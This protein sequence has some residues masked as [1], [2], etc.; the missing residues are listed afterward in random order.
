MKKLSVLFLS[1]V[2]LS[3]SVVSCSSDDDKDEAASIEGKWELFQEITD[4]NDCTPTVVEILKGG[5]YIGS[6]SEYYDSKCN[7]YT[8][9]GDWSRN[10]NM[11]SMQDEGDD[12]VNKSEIIE[13]TSST[14]KLKEVDEEGTWYIVLKRK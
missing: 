10:G 11:L 1:L 14:L 9:K 8:F 7:T 2:A 5:K 4:E 12:E 13:L 3:L 6:G